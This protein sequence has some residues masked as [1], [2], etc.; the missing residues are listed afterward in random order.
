M[1][2]LE[3]R[4]ELIARLAAVR[5]STKTGRALQ[6]WASYYAGDDM[7]AGAPLLG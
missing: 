1:R 4:S 5:N 7:T 6:D 2:L 3:K